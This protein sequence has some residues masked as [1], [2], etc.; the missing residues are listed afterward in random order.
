MDF[1]R[2]HGCN[3]TRDLGGYYTTEGRQIATKRL[4][5]S[6]ALKNIGRRGVHYLTSQCRVRTIVDLRTEGE[7]ERAPL[8]DVSPIRIRHIPVLETAMQGIT[9]DGVSTVQ[10]VRSIVRSGMSE[11]E[12]MGK[13][14]ENIVSSPQAMKAYG[15]LF[16]VLLRQEEGATLF[17][18][19]HGRDRTGIAAMLILTAL[20]VDRQQVQADYLLPTQKQARQE[21]LATLLEKVHYANHREAEFA[22]AFARPSVER[23]NVVYAW[24]E[25][26]YGSMQQ[27]LHS[28]IGL[29]EKDILQL[30]QMYLE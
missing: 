17:F 2:F 11:A 25:S 24:A 14:Y 15:H 1:L 18:C 4:I 6:G 23:I 13:T 21:R 8:P 29:G 26:H 30:K 5:R 9:K 22:R 7:A 19:S 12:F 28:A 27:Y 10:M 16:E 3:N 20:G